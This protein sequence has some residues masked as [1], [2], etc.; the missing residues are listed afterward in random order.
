MDRHVNRDKKIEIG[1]DELYSS[2]R[3]LMSVSLPFSARS[4]SIVT[5]WSAGRTSFPRALNSL[6]NL[7]CAH[8]IGSLF[9]FGCLRCRQSQAKCCGRPHPVQSVPAPCPVDAGVAGRE[10]AGGGH[11]EVSRAPW[12]RLS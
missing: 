10:G 9:Q 11:S 6:P 3:E 7:L 8:G 5:E 12:A 2:L 4:E 1:D